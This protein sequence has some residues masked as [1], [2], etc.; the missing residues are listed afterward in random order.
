LIPYESEEMESEPALIPV[1]L[2]NAL[3]LSVSHGRKCS[4]CLYVV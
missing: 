1:E 4:R 3:C 2:V